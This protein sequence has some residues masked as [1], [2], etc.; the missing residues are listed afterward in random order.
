[1]EFVTTYLAK[2]DM[3]YKDPSTGMVLSILEEL[4][5]PGTDYVSIQ[6]HDDAG[7]KLEVYENGCVEFYNGTESRR[8]LKKHV[9]HELV[10]QMWRF[11]QEGDP[12]RIR[13]LMRSKSVSEV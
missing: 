8:I 10:I 3:V 7:W 6:L 9:P 12:E 2:Q 4:E 13:K 5:S 1:M 11:M